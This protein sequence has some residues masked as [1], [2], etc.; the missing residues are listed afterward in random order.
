MFAL[1]RGRGHDLGAARRLTVQRPARKYVSPD[2]GVGLDVL[3]VFSC[4]SNSRQF[5]VFVSNN[6]CDADF[7]GTKSTHVKGER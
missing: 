4:F 1:L 6:E 3:N 7:Y 5:L 2:S